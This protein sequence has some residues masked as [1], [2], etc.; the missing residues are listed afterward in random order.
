VAFL[1]TLKFASV[2]GR[3]LSGQLVSLSLDSG[4]VEL[5]QDVPIVV[6]DDIRIEAAGFPL[7]PSRVEKISEQRE[8][9]VSIR[10]KH[11]LD[12]APRDRLIVKL[13]TGDYSQEIQQLNT[14]TIV[15]GLW[16]RA[17]GRA[18]PGV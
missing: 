15:G 13:Y 18:A 17:F 10:F 5:R 1:G 3:C 16:K 14:P 9:R 12:A 2:N 7:L 4:I 8:S 11:S 6:G